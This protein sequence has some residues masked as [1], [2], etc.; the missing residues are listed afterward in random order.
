MM[1]A[2][3]MVG[4]VFATFA[5]GSSGLAEARG[6]ADR[7][8]FLFG[9]R[10]VEADVDDNAI[11]HRAHFTSASLATLGLLVK[12]MAASAADFPAISTAPGFTY[13][14]NTQLQVFERSSASLGPVFVERPET[15]GRGKV[16]FGF[17]YLF[18]DFD[19]L[20]GKNLDHLSFRHLGH[21][22]C[23]N[24]PNPPPSPNVPAFERDT[25]DVFFQKFTLQSHVVSLFATYGITERWDVNILLPF[26]FTHF[27]VRAQAVLND[28]S[29]T[30][31][32]SFDNATKATTEVRSSSDDPVGIGDLLLR[33][34][35]HLVDNNGFNLAAGLTLRLPTGDEGD[36]QGLGDT[37]TTPFLALSQEYGR[38]HLHGTGGIEFN[39]DDSDRTRARYAAGIAF[40]VIEQLVLNVDVV[41]SSY[42]K[43]DRLSVQVP[44]FV[45]APGTSEA[46]PAT[47]PTTRTFSTKIRP[48][49]VDLAV[50]FKANI[51]GT[52]VGYANVFLPLNDD[53]IRADVIPSAGLEVS[54]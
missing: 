46:T 14:F 37:M 15:L 53:G 16:D 38:F 2:K 23:C 34:K 41:G 24:T 27:R 6:L 5:L 32:H 10:G 51:Y 20:N 9:D 40:S 50:G 17:S 11:P 36:F 18:I 8:S 54:F 19:E 3:I 1:R 44:Q 33:T 21:N 28:E 42:L 52:L 47:L 31:T 26:V 29:G 39:W 49:I 4:V 22:D 45:N 13:Q 12:Q 43:K 7:I 30:H 48:D 25:A 35:Y